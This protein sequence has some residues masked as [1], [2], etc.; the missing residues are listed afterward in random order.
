MQ[1]DF[2]A[3]IDARLKALK[4]T[5]SQTITAA[6]VTPPPA[7]SPAPTASVS[8]TLA[9]PAQGSSSSVGGDLSMGSAITVPDAPRRH[10]MA[11]AEAPTAAANEKRRHSMAITEAVS[12]SSKHSKYFKYACVHILVST[13]ECVYICVPI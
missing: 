6:V 3:E 10:S 4:R 8:L 7:P 5:A 1:K 11:L 13:C 12:P 2:I 9:L